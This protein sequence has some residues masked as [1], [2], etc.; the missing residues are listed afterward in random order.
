[1]NFIIYNTNASFVIELH[2]KKGTIQNLF[3][4]GLGHRIHHTTLLLHSL[5]ISPI[6]RH[7]PSPPKSHLTT[8]PPRTLTQPHSASFLI[9]HRK[10]SPPPRQFPPPTAQTFRKLTEIMRWSLK[11]VIFGVKS[12][13]LG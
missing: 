3:F 13:F 1:M 10:I 7:P 12:W 11:N 9:R 6:P 5:N 2:F 4:I 8:R